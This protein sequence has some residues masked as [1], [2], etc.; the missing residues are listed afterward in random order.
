DSLTDKVGIFRNG[1]DL[2]QAVI[3][4]KEL[5]VRSKDI[6]LKS[7]TGISPE[8]TLALRMPGMIRLALCISQGALMRTESRGSHA[9]EDYPK[10]DDVNWLK[11]TLAYWKKDSELPYLDYEP[12][13]ITELPPG[14]RG[15]GESAETGQ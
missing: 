7:R 5:L 12:V 4:L 9:R 13:N 1:S 14:D 2:Q 11:R 15:Y 8:L 3:N 10:R 6:Q